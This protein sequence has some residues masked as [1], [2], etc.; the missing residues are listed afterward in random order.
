M[1]VRR[2][3]GFANHAL[4]LASLMLL[5]PL[6]AAAQGIQAPHTT[7]SV[8]RWLN[9]VLIFGVGGWWI[10]RKLKVA[11]RRRA[12]KIAATIAEAEAACR[13]ALERLQAA[14]AKLAGVNREAQEMRDRARHDSAAEAERIAALAR[15]EAARV[16][17]AAD[18]E[19]DAAERAAVNRLRE[20]AIA[21][22]LERAR[23]LV[24]ERLTTAVDA[25]LFDRFI[26]Q[27][28]QMG[29]GA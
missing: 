12:E 17:R 5:A 20:M 6:A 18:A 29:S 19:I 25:R 8:F 26:G 27:L 1:P 3:W 11:F 21:K 2:Q 9:F 13:Q 7:E 24:S 4:G 15:V 28:G 23:A 16:E 10:W 14:E 22:T